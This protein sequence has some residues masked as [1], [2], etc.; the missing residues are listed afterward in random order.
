M[1]QRESKRKKKDGAHRT[2]IWVMEVGKLKSQPLLHDP[3]LVTLMK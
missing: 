3:Q 2:Q 1:K